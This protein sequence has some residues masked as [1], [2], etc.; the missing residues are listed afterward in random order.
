MQIVLLVQSLLSVVWAASSSSCNLIELFHKQERIRWG[1]FYPSL[2]PDRI[3]AVPFS[4]IGSTVQLVEII[5]WPFSWV[6]V[7][8]HFDG[9]PLEAQTDS[10]VINQHLDRL[11]DPRVKYLTFFAVL[12]GWAT[13]TFLDTIGTRGYVQAEQMLVMTL[14]DL[15]LYENGPLDALPE[16]LEVRLIDQ[17]HDFEKL[18]AYRP[19]PVQHFYRGFSADS[20]R[21]PQMHSWGIFDMH[22]GECVCTTQIFV[23]DPEAAIVGMVSTAEPWRNRG[24]ASHLLAVALQ[25]A[26]K[27]CHIRRAMLQATPMAVNMYKRMG[28]ETIATTTKCEYNISAELSNSCTLI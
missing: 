5:G 17:L 18:I 4:E 11:L 14:E 6:D 24:L 21:D 27:A 15:S 13:T 25:H 12:D 22:T 20:L 16:G 2:A 3:R 26:V 10:Q 1:Q 19:L 8:L 7:T 28:F 9:S 23:H